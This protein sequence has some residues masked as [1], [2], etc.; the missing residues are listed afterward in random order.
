MNSNCLHFLNRATQRT[1]RF[2]RVIWFALPLALSLMGTLQVQAQIPLF[3]DTFENGTISDSDTIKGFWLQGVSSEASAIEANGKL[4]ISAGKSTSDINA[5]APRLYSGEP[6]DDFNFFKRKLRFVADVT[7]TGNDSTQGTLR[8][9]LTGGSGSIYFEDDALSVMFTGSNTVTL[10]AKRDSSY[11]GVESGTKMVNA[12]TLAGPVTKFDLTLD[13]TNYTLVVYYQGGAGVSTFSGLHG[14]VAAQWGTDGKSTAQFEVVRSWGFAGKTATATVDNFSITSYAPPALFEDTF[15]SGS[16]FNSDLETGIWSTTLPF[17]STAV[18]NTGPLQLTATSA[19]LD[20]VLANVCTPIQS[21][22]N[23]FD[24]QLRVRATL[25]MSGTGAAAYNRGRLVLAS[26][27]GTSKSASDAIYI[28]IRGDNVVTSAAKTDG[29]GVDAEDYYSGVVKNLMSTTDLGV[30]MGGS[31]IRNLNFVLN[32][33]RY[34]FI[35]AAQEVGG[36][37]NTRGSDVL[38]FSGS[39]KLDRSKWGANGDSSLMLESIRLTQTQSGTTAVAAWDNVRV[40]SDTTKLLDEPFWTLTVSYPTSSTTTQSGNFRLWLPSTEPVIRGIIFIGPGDGEDRQYQA[41]DLAAQE[42]GRAMGFGVIG[43]ASAA[44]MNLTGDDTTNIK[45]A[46]QAVMDRAATVSGHPEISNAPICITGFS[47]GSFDS[48]Y[49]VRNWPERVVAFVPFCGGEWSSPTLTDA[50]KKVPGLFTAGSL[51]TNGATCPSVMKPMFNWWRGQGAQV[52][53]V[54]N[55]GVNHNTGGNQGW[56]S[57]W[58]WMVEVA[59]LRYPRPMVPSQT[60]GVIPTLVNLEETSGWLGDNDSFTYTYKNATYSNVPNV[61]HTFTPIAPYASYVGT[62]STASWMPN[63][64]TARIYR[65]M[66]STDRVSR[67]AIPMQTPLRITSP[68]QFCEPVTVGTGVPIEV[69]PRDFDNTNAIASMDFYDGN[70]WLGAVASGPAWRWTTTFSSSGWHSLSVVATDVLGNKRD[71]FRVVS[72]IPA[73]FPP[74]AIRQSTSALAA[75]LVSGTVSGIDPEGNTVTYAIAQQ[76]A[77]GTATIN[78][79]T[80]AYTYISNP[81]Y[82]GTDTFTFTTN[83]GALTS[84]PSPVAVAVSVGSVGNIATV[85]ATTGANSAE[86]T[87]TWSA[88]TNASR[89]SIERSTLSNSG[90]VAVG[91]V[92]VP[93]LTFTDTKLTFLQTY[94]YRVAAINSISQSN[95]TSIVSSQPNN[96]YS[97]VGAIPSITAAPGSTTGDVTVTWSAATNAS[98]YRVEYGYSLS[99]TYYL[100][101]NLS[102]SSLSYTKSNVQGAATLYVRVLPSNPAYAGTYSAVASSLPYVAP[103]ADG[104]RYVNFGTTEITEGTG[105]LDTPLGDGIPNIIKYAMGLKAYDSNWN[106]VT[107]SPTDMPYVHQQ[108]VNG[109]SYLT[110]SFAHNK[111]ATD[112]VIKV[113]V[114]DDPKGTWTQLDPFLAANQVSVTDN[115][116][117]VGVETIV[118]KDTQPITSATKRFM[119]VRVT[120]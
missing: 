6:R 37:S 70:T 95:Y 65:A 20:Y 58:S 5:V 12:V 119:R 10:S 120:H 94:Y 25:T 106:P 116:P 3:V 43:Y 48:C 93:Q 59:K 24:H 64:T 19:A 18:E 68:A 7:I 14:V 67:Y 72:V 41:H 45:L 112:L 57:V 9:A 1:S 30:Y 107:L 98:A 15:G 86:I 42:A 80:G 33:K 22:F 91:T 35:G 11:S 88:A 13:A 16:V 73:N 89:Y 62:A 85:A 83:D 110:C 34:C 27:T 32:S 63:E 92:D 51:D 102:A 109:T 61:T 69:D 90:F 60:P 50:A 2:P 87:L 17:T 53:F 52:A 101:A 104:W 40:E 4:T 82:G 78:S 44:R 49:L 26:E 28:G 113:E 21:R 99:G 103:T 114:T 115:T 111:S 29:S 96:P 8:F 105:D 79:T 39:H 71:A 74:L 81:G 118:V 23:F 36:S 55:W 75:T 97:P 54:I 46:V 76:P 117:S 56:E 31:I 108:T 66:N 84:D 100:A 77:H 47:R 38:R